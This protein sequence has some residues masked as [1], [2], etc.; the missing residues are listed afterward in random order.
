MIALPRLAAKI[1][2]SVL[3]QEPERSYW[4]A[5]LST[6]TPKQKQRLDDILSR[7]EIAFWGNKAQKYISILTRATV[8]LAQ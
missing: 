2:R 1:R 3:L 7:A 8:A 6:M 4:A 5:N